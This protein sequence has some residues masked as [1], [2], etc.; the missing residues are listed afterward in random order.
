VKNVV[1]TAD[2][3]NGEAITVS[4]NFNFAAVEVAVK[5]CPAGT[6]VLI[7]TLNGEGKSKNGDFWVSFQ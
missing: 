6:N 5:A 1:G 7:L 4:A 3:V 2:I